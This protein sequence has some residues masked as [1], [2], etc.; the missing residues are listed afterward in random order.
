MIVS[1]LE[2]NPAQP[3]STVIELQDLKISSC[4]LSI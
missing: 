4:M 2:R 3:D 1:R